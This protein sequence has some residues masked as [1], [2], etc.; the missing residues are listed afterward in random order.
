MEMALR[1]MPVAGEPPKRSPHGDPEPPTPA[2]LRAL[3]ASL[4][5]DRMEEAAPL[6][7]DVVLLT[8]MTE[9]YRKEGEGGEE[10]VRSRLVADLDALLRQQWYFWRDAS[11]RERVCRFARALM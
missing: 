7:T 9:D 5:A 1:M 4:C 10:A 2:E 11:E 6:L 3:W 8:A